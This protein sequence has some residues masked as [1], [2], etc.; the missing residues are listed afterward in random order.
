M[1]LRLQIELLRIAIAEE[2][3]RA[4]KINWKH[5]AA[6]VSS[7]G[8]ADFECFKKYMQLR[9][10]QMKQESESK[11]EAARKGLWTPEEVNFLKVLIAVN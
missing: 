3:R 9:Y 11:L 10:A 5:I 7:T 4:G 8:L 6:K 2:T 1:I